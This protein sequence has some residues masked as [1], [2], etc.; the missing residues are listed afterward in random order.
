MRPYVK[1]PAAIYTASFATVRAE[2]RLDRFDPGMEA[3]AVR[4]IHAC[5]MVDIA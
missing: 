2:A 1:D 3:L 5:G 4:L